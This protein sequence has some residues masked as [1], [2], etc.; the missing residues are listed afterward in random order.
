[1]ANHGS[2]TDTDADG[3]ADQID[4]ANSD[5]CVPN[6]PAASC[7]LDNDGSINSVDSDDDGDNYTDTDETAAGS[8]PYSAA[9]VPADNDSDF[10]PDVTDPDDD[11]DGVSDVAEATNATNPLQADTDGDGL[12]DDAE[13]SV[14]TDSDGFIDA[15]ESS[16]TESAPLQCR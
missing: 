9:S 12:N 8:D 1:L 11:N 3:L 15:L 7:D 4:P 10:I 16:L 14:D 5:A 13:G 2:L 6:T